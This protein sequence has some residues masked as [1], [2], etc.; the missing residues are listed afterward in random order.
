MFAH[1]FPRPRTSWSLA[2]LALLWSPLARA[3]EFHYRDIFIGA[4]AGGMAG[5]MVGLADDPTAA[6]YNPGGLAHA[7]HENVTVNATAVLY[8]Q[9]TLENYL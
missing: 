6:W 7:S 8:R 2:L 1:F 4:R 3:G 5:A 9:L